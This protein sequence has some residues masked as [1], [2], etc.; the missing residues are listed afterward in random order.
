[1]VRKLGELPK[2]VVFN[3]GTEYFG[4][5]SVFAFLLT[6]IRFSLE[7]QFCFRDCNGKWMLIFVNAIVNLLH[8]IYITQC[9]HHNLIDLCKYLLMQSSLWQ[10]VR[11]RTFKE[12]IL[13][14]PQ[15][16]ARCGHG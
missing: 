14:I 12:L 8:C 9:L 4:N 11:T 6:A 2:F 7:L 3:S 15:G 13:D 5:S 16:S 10:M 1:M